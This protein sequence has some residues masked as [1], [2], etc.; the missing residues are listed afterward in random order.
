MLR[1]LAGKKNLRFLQIGVFTGNASAWLL[2][3]ILTDES[4]VLVD[5]DPWCGNIQH[6]VYNWDDIQEA[7]KEQVKPHGSKVKTYKMF[8][9]EY[10]ALSKEKDFDF[11]YVDGDHSPEGFTIDADGSFPLL[12][13]GGIMAFDDYEWRH[14]AGIEFDPKPAMDKWLDKHK[15]DVEILSKGWQIWMRKK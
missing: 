9:K 1:E 10:F 14:P 15:D 2:N 8:S 5:V 6:E 12:K 13:S 4:S 3:N 7:Y 11:I